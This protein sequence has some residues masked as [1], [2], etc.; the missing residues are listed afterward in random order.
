M[1]RP[2]CLLLGAAALLSALRAEE[3][4]TTAARIERVTVYGD[5]AEVV[6]RF[7]AQAAAGEHTLVFDRLP[8]ATDLGSVRAEGRGDLTLIDL[9]AEVVQTAEAE[10]EKVRAL[11]T[12]LKEQEDLLK[13]V[14]LTDARISQRRSALDKVLGR[15]TSVGK[16]SANPDMDPAKW[17]AY[18]SFHVEALAKLDQETLDSKAHAEGLRR[19][20]DRLRRELAV[21][22][23]RRDQDRFRNL[24]R[25]KIALAAAGEI[26]LS[27]SYVV[28]GPSWRPLYDVRADTRAGKLTVAYQAELRQATGEDWK[29]VSLRLST[30]QPSIGGREPQL[31]A[32]HVR[33]LEP[34]PTPTAAPVAMRKLAM[35]GLAE[36]LDERSD[37]ASAAMPSAPKTMIRPAASVITGG[38]SALFVIERA[39]DVPADNQPA[40]AQIA[41]Q[42]FDASFRHTCVPKS[43]PH[44]Y[45]KATALN[46]SDYPFLPGPTA[47]FLDG[48]FVANA[49]MDLVPAGQEF[50][51]HL[52]VDQS[53]SV[54]R[55]EVAKREEESGLFG[56]KTRRTAYEYLFRLKNSKPVAAELTILDQLPVSTHEKIKVV[57][58]EPKDETAPGFKV[59]E[60]KT[61]EW[62]LRLAPGEKRDLPFRFAVERPEDFQLSNR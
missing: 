17:A 37:S 16:E 51:T 42:T 62:T 40:K 14:A 22:T 41:Q 27:L 9:R 46:R 59:R 53:L 45:L 43:S 34:M 15:L 29:G 55:K 20:S 23:T 47:V 32:W 8:G 56:P 61:A 48:S 1:L 6:R 39:Y 49:G 4:N 60:D 2:T 54:E 31:A 35:S 33:K 19:E 13:E 50:T 12:Q 57:L 44:V 28:A 25:V 18:L 36:A 10:D 58:V 7:R 26:D 52:G 30:A 3:I 21:L 5:R 24:A 11:N 38:A